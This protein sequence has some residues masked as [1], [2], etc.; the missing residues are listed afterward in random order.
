MW[1]V[2]VRGWARGVGRF[3]GC[4]KKEVETGLG[5]LDGEVELEG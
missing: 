4:V 1:R 2:G 3:G 5:G